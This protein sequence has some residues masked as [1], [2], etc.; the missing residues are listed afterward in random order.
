MKSLSVHALGPVYRHRDEKKRQYVITGYGFFSRQPK[1][2]EVLVESLYIAYKPH[3]NIPFLDADI[4]M[5]GMDL[6]SSVRGIEKA[7]CL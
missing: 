2:S 4:E 7:V 5:S 3:W 6:R 1:L